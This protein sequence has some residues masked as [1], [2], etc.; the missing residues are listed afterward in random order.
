MEICTLIE[1]RPLALPSAEAFVSSDSSA[2]VSILA[3]LIASSPASLAAAGKIVR[4]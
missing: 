3:F 1:E 4:D 2:S